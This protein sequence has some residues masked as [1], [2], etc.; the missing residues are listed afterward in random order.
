[1]DFISTPAGYWLVIT[2][3]F[4]LIELAT[5]GLVTIW[6]AAGG[7]I[8]MIL[9]LAGAGLPAQVA[10]FVLVSVVCIAAVRPIA[11][12]HF[13]NNL[14]KTNIDSVIGKKLI[15]KTGIDN[16]KNSGKVELEGSIWLARSTDDNITIE[17]GEE[18]VVEKIVGNKLIVKKITY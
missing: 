10:V 13:N 9:A 5:V 7:F 15:V 6:F 2:V 18:V 12:K 14:T 16:M 4:A 1:M 3:V 11:A 8:A 17:E